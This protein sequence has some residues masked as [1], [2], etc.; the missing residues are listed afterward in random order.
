MNKIRPHLADSELSDEDLM[1]YVNQAVTAQEERETKLKMASHKSG[2]VN[3]LNYTKDENDLPEMKSGK[4]QQP[5]NSKFMAALEAVKSEV[6]RLSQRLNEPRSQNTPYY[7]GQT[8]GPN[9]NP[10]PNIRACQPCQDKSNTST[11]DHCY[12]CGSGEHWSKGCHKRIQSRSAKR[13]PGVVGET[14]HNG[15]EIE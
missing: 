4:Q 5:E 11:C 8:K 10:S 13:G 12:F 9:K 6:S 7:R 2:K 14:G 3:V 15:G 1:G